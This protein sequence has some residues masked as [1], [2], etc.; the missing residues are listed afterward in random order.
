MKLNDANAY[1]EELQNIFFD[2]IGKSLSDLVEK[3]DKSP[4]IIK[5]EVQYYDNNKLVQ[6]DIRLQIINK[7]NILG[8]YETKNFLINH[9]KYMKKLYKDDFLSQ[10]NLE[11]VFLK[12]SQ[13]SYKTIFYLNALIQ[14]DHPNNIEMLC[15]EYYQF[16]DCFLLLLNQLIAKIDCNKKLI[17]ADIS[18]DEKARNFNYEL[19]NTFE[20]LCTAQSNTAFKNKVIALKGTFFAQLDQFLT[21]IIAHRNIFR[22][23]LLAKSMLCVV[24]LEL[25]VFGDDL[26]RLEAAIDLEKIVNLLEQVE[27]VEEFSKKGDEKYSFICDMIDIVCY[28][29]KT[30]YFIMNFAKSEKLFKLIYNSYKKLPK[31]LAK[32]DIL[33][34]TL[35][36]QGNTFTFDRQKENFE[37]A[38][39]KY[40]CDMAGFEAM[41]KVKNLTSGGTS[42][43][44]KYNTDYI[45]KYEVDRKLYEHLKIYEIISSYLETKF[46]NGKILMSEDA[47][48]R[49]QISMEYI[50]QN[51]KFRTRF[52]DKNILEFLR[53]IYHELRAV[54]ENSMS[55]EQIR[56]QDKLYSF[57]SKICALCNA[58]SLSYSLKHFLVDLLNDVLKNAAH[59]QPQF[60]AQLALTQFT[61]EEEIVTKLY[62][63]KQISGTL[64]TLVCEKNQSISNA[65]YELLSNIC[66]CDE[67]LQ[68]IYDKKAMRFNLLKSM[69]LCNLWLREDHIKNP[70]KVY[71]ELAHRD[72][73]YRFPICINIQCILTSIP[74]FPQELISKFEAQPVLSFLKR[75][76]DPK[77]QNDLKFKFEYLAKHTKPV[78]LGESETNGSV[79]EEA[80]SVQTDQSFMEKNGI[81]DILER[82]PEVMK[83]FDD[84]IKGLDDF[85]RQCKGAQVGNEIFS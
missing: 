37:L 13:F 46:S 77:V 4:E 10:L 80:K 27:F 16:V 79:F 26:E 28:L 41:D 31:K 32:F 72:M 40:G 6:K 61:G 9:F 82:T 55:A 74:G 60:E 73:T 15:N 1:S 47:K 39:E 35:I 7:A 3:I 50:V 18:K 49:I 24:I 23:D 85:L 52:F 34:F 14:A 42:L 29:S 44:S 33:I 57:T 22:L 25:G 54:A 63:Q 75:L 12:E 66:Y 65:A 19:Y 8:S 5:K 17:S 21:K 45:Y 69:E 71:H 83:A 68:D 43:L 62:K 48:Q 84:K 58:Q 30:E 64:M 20:L 11:D 36:E 38:K 81:L 2:H 67:V 53:I 56:L 78:E 59:E 70:D 51:Q 76:K